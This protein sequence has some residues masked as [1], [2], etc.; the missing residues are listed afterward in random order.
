M[1]IDTPKKIRMNE[2]KLPM[3]QRLALDGLCGLVDWQGLSI[4][5]IRE[6]LDVLDDHCGNESVITLH[7]DEYYGAGA[8]F[9]W[10]RYE[11][12]AEVTKR[13]ETNR[14][15]EGLGPLGER[16]GLRDVGAHERAGTNRFIR[17]PS[18]IVG[19]RPAQSESWPAGN[20]TT[21]RAS[22]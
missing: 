2:D 15:R 5:K 1:A 17:P 9:E 11:T 3:A 21:K 4:I 18:A 10:S 8:S 16:I 7:N 13:I 12:E 14:K 19:R 20:A 22:P 6:H